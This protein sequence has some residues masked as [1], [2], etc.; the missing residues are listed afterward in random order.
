MGDGIE[1]GEADVR[2][3]RPYRYLVSNYF[4]RIA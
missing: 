4:S 2:V 3:G 1:G